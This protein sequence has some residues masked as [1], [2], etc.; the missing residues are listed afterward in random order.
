VVD[1]SDAVR[2]RQIDIMSLIGVNRPGGRLSL[3]ELR[4]TV[5]RGCATESHGRPFSRAFLTASVRRD[6]QC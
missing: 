3:A 1:S 2:R 6:G 5:R 4:V